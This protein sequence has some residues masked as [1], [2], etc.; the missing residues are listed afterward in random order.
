MADPAR[1]LSAG[2][3][4]PTNAQ[5]PWLAALAAAWQGFSEPSPLAFRA[6][7]L[8]LSVTLGFCLW[9]FSPATLAGPMG[10][11][12]PRSSLDAEGFVTR[13]ALRAGR[14]PPD[15]PRLF[16]LGTSTIAQAIGAG[17][18]LRD[19][20]EAGTGQAWEVVN[21]ATPLQS[22]TDQFALLETSLASQTTE[23]PLVLIALGFGVQRLRWTNEQFLDLFAQ[24]RLGLTSDWADDE[25]QLL[26]GAVPTRSGVYVLDNRT[27]VLL[28]GSEALIRLALQRPARRQIDQFAHGVP[29]DNP[30]RRDMIGS[31]TRNG[32]VRQDA[33]LDQIARLANRVETV[34]NTMLVLIEE[35]L[36]PALVAEQRL[37]GLRAALEAAISQRAAAGMPVFWPIMTEAGLTAADYFDELH[38]LPGAAQERVQTALSDHVIALWQDLGGEN[39][40]N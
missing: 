8:S 9:F 11:F 22:P 40:G 27:F 10:K 36:S 31:E 6:F 17:D 16:V 29:R 7:C 20:L 4:K 12:L 23:S 14:L 26:G 21:L 34:P 32:V 1:S 5:P 2:A 24:A 18:A 13:A 25:A 30:T 39:D 19:Q 3:R 28:N 33:L 37:E 35:G 38:V 15:R